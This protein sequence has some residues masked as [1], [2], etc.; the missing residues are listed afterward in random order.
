MKTFLEMSVGRRCDHGNRQAGFT[1]VELLIV[2]AILG[3]LAG[4][5]T[6]SLIGLTGTATTQGCKTELGIVQTGMDAYLAD[7]G[8]QPLPTPAAATNDMGNPVPLYTAN[9]NPN[10]VPPINSYI[11]NPATHQK[12]TWDS[13][14]K[15]T[16][17]GCS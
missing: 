1:L 7:H 3:I 9:P 16:Q 12:Y 15:V 4:I 8:L 17:V 5:V 11:R 6:L 13:T 14:G 2:V 10:A